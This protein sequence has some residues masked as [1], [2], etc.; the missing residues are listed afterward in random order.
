MKISYKQ[1]AVLF[2]LFIIKFLFIFIAEF[3]YSKVSQLGDSHRYLESTLTFSASVLYSST[4][5]MEFTG[6]IVKYLQPPLYHFPAMILS[7]IGVV[8]SFNALKKRDVFRNKWLLYIFI[9]LNLMPSY[10]IWTSIHSK[11]AIA[12]LFMS[13]FAVLLINMIDK[14]EKVS[15]V[16]LLFF[17]YLLLIFKPQY[18]VAIISVAIYLYLLI[19]FRLNAYLS[20]LLFLCIFIVQFALLVSVSEYIDLV[21]LNMYSHFDPENAKSTRENIYFVNE[22]D[23]FRGM[24][25]GM[26]LSFWGPTINETITRPVWAVFFLESLVIMLVFV[27]LYFGQIYKLLSYKFNF[28][29]FGVLFFSLFWLLLVHYPFGIFNPGSAIRYRQNFYPFLV[30]LLIFMYHWVTKPPNLDGEIK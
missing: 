3:G 26:F 23:F 6:A 29:A 2:Y 5:L 7:F 15:K 19:K 18:F 21:T 4:A 20:I 12:T 27:F 14:R 11:E 9:L 17:C 30:P 16:L 28:I 22:G 24:L 8:I 1:N 10:L 25:H 13:Y